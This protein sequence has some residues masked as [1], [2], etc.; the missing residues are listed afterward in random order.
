[1]Q[2]L[3][4]PSWKQSTMKQE[5]LKP[6]AALRKRMSVKSTSLKR[7]SLNSTSITKSFAKLSKAESFVDRLYQLKKN[8]ISNSVIGRKKSE[9][10]FQPVKFKARPFVNKQPFIAMKST[11]KLTIP[12]E[13]SF[14]TM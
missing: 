13:S 12:M 4:Q 11:K 2:R 6:M 8:S 10:D 3:M 14:K 1:M 7:N 9:D 5:S